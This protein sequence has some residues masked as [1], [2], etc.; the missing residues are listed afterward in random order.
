MP[1]LLQR[2]WPIALGLLLVGGTLLVLG[3][4]RDA[5]TLA[6]VDKV[7]AETGRELTIAGGAALIVWPR[8]GLVIRQASINGVPGLGDAPL[9][10][11][12][13][14]EI[15]V[16][17]RSLVRGRLEVERVTLSGARISL[18]R[19][20]DGQVNWGSLPR[21]GAEVR[22][23]SPVDRSTG[24]VTEP[25]PPLAPSAGTALGTGPL[26][27]GGLHLAASALTWEDRATGQQSGLGD[28]SMDLV[29]GP[30]GVGLHLSLAGHL[31]APAGVRLAAS[32]TLELGMAGAFVARDIHAHLSGLPVNAAPADTLEL[33]GNLS[34][35]PSAPVRFDLAVDGLDLDA[36]WPRM[37]RLAPAPPQAQ[38]MP[39]VVSGEPAH[40]DPSGLSSPN[41]GPR[42]VASDL[43][44]SPT[45]EGS[46]KLGRLRVAG[47]HMQGVD[48]SAKGEGG[49][50]RLEHRVGDFYGGGIAGTL[51][52]DLRGDAPR[53]DLQSAA[54]G[55]QCG[56]LLADLSGARRLTGR[57]D[58]SI[59]AVA[60]GAARTS[61]LHS[62]RGSLALHLVEG[63]LVGVDLGA[64]IEG[65]RT[66]LAPGA[67]QTQGLDGAPGTVVDELSANAVAAGGVLRSDDLSA[68]GPWFR[69]TGS[70]TLS[71]VDGRLDLQLAPVLVKPPAGR[72]LKE[73]EGIP[74]PIQVSGT[75]AAPVWRV[76]AA[77]AL[78]EVARRKLDHRGD[79]LMRDLDRRT[80]VK[81]LGE[82]LRG[83]LGR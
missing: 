50:W 33:S 12:Q 38:V 78:R 75:L 55:F 16:Q 57:A 79:A 31:A 73:L 42:G 45:V 3:R 23:P 67:P 6:L 4:A 77:S 83:L 70:G 29:P 58:V 61:I 41:L 19:G 18:I 2:L 39:A 37:K 15:R 28:L 63:T 80:G 65:A 14:V 9:I 1:R 47:L 59:S 69:A 74:I 54:L 22:G 71:L 13:R 17:P 52:L 35:G 51:L 81:G 49:V 44:S 43:P 53:L 5:L 76:D 56:P 11:V 82:T 30:S 10:A 27:P 64:L 7:K 66:S 32:A 46:L 8:P 20:P 21:S 48:I 25:V 36:D 60:S 24:A 34:Y 68:R 26:P 40:A 72:G 62:L